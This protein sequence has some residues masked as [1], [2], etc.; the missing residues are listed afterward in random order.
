MDDHPTR[1]DH[2]GL[3]G[4]CA[5]CA[6]EIAAL[7]AQLEAAELRLEATDGALARHIRETPA[8]PSEIADILQVARDPEQ[9]YWRVVSYFEQQ[10][11]EAWRTNASGES[12]SGNDSLGPLRTTRAEAEADGCASGLPE[13]QSATHLAAREPQVTE[14]PP[15]V[16]AVL[17]DPNVRLMGEDEAAQRAISY[18]LTQSKAAADLVYRPGWDHALAEVAL[19]M[20]NR[21]TDGR[22]QMFDQLRACQERKEASEVA[23]PVLE[24]VGTVARL[25]LQEEAIRMAGTT[26]TAPGTPEG[27]SQP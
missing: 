18:L 25:F 17:C 20:D 3:R 10:S 13:W 16:E 8:T 23:D 5:A 15:E 26:A 22:P 24:L 2:A 11:F 6:A 21:T 14:L 12:A 9:C 27:G 1:A 7:R 4:H 19:L